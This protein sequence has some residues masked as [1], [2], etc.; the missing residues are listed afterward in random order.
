MTK[1]PQEVMLK[2]SRELPK[3]YPPAYFLSIE[4][5]NILCFKTRQK[6]DLSDANGFPSQ[7]TVILGDNGVGKTTLLRSLAGMEPTKRSLTDQE[8]EISDASATLKKDR[9]C[10]TVRFASLNG[11]REGIFPGFQI[12]SSD[13]SGKRQIF[14]PLEAIIETHFMY[15]SELNKW[16][17]IFDNQ[18]IKSSKHFR[19]GF[20]RI[21]GSSSTFGIALG[22]EELLGLRCYG[23]GAN[24][25]MGETSL[26]EALSSDSCSSLFADD[27]TLINAEEWLLQADYAVARSTSN[28]TARLEQR[29][30]LIQDTLKKLLPDISDIRIAPADDNNPR[31]AAEFLTPYGWVPLKGL[32]LGYKT[33]IAWT[34]DFAARMMERYPH[35][36]DPLAE[37]AVVLVDEIDLHLHPKWQRTI[38]SFL[39]ERFPNT[40]FIVTAHSPLVVQAAKNA[41]IVLL[42]R[43]GDHVVID[44]DPEIIDNWRVEQI[45]S[46]VFELPS[47]HSPDLAPLI[48]RR[49][50]LLAKSKLTA[51]DERELKKLEAQIGT[52]PTAESPEDIRAM[53]IIRKAAKLLENS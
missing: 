1:A 35:S 49:R 8:P 18:A 27:K 45:L 53:D 46:S 30:H 38:M 51:K 12:K 2:T 23:Y 32:S 16:R 6:L 7:W 52:I 42:R 41:N 29:L 19:Q 11:S 40:Q 34:V 44:N 33:V 15:G 24:R 9:I 43:E 5:E 13:S 22:E 36:T 47:P 50:K 28:N 10:S 4:L 39:T 3:D 37:P 21:E 26:S 17:E 20:L 31:P 25:R 48:E 14:R